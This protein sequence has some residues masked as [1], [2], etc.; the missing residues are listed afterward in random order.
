MSEIKKALVTACLK[1]ENREKLRKALAPA[2]VIFCAPSDPDA[3]QIIAEAVQTADVC[4]LNGDLD[5]SILAGA[6]I[7]WIHCCHAGLDRSARP[8]V[9]ERGIVLTG[10]SG[11]SAPALAEH[12]LMFLLSFTYN[13]PL[14]LQ[15]Q[16]RRRWDDARACMQKTALHGKTIGVIGLGNTGREVACLAKALDMTVLGWRR[17]KSPV[18]CVDEVYASE[19]NADLNAMLARCDFVVLCIELNDKTFH[20]MRAGQFCAMKST[21]FLIN[22]GRGKLIDEAALVHALRTGEIAGA[23]LDTFE[24]EPLP[25]ESPLWE[26]PNVIITPHCTPALPDREERM[27]DYVYQNIRAYREGGA[28][29]NRLTEKNIFSGV[30]R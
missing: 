4:I 26:M 18:A 8:E 27:L 25:V 11:R 16:A 2:E 3:P 12:V 10:S 28:F 1:P 19:E 5:A 22:M 13:L 7:K 24:V 20:M 23:G 30:R 17:S 15:A 21:A 14:L 6:Q 9:F 29:V